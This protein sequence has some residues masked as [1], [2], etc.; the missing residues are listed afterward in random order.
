VK[1]LWAA[2]QPALKTLLVPEA[3]PY[4]NQMAEVILSRRAQLMA[5]P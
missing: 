1:V 5:R 4:C 3:E 2:Q